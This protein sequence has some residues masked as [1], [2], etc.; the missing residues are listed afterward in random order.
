MSGQLMQI[1]VSEG[2]QV[3]KGTTLFVIDSRNAQLE[4]EAAFYNTQEAR[5]AFYPKISL[6]GILGWGNN[7]G[8]I[9]NP[10]SLLL[11]ALASV[12]QPIFAQGKLKANLKINQLS[13]E[14]IA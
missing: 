3:K 9:P 8:M 4:L 2:Q 14:D 12:V 13:E 5:A 7:S 10:G 1:C 11:N 6:Q